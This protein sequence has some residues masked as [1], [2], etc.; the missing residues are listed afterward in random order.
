MDLLSL[1]EWHPPGEPPVPPGEPRPVHIAR[2]VAANRSRG[3]PQQGA[4]TKGG[5]RTPATDIYQE[6]VRA[7]G[8]QGLDRERT[9]VANQV[10][11]WYAWYVT[12]DRA[13]RLE[14]CPVEREFYAQCQRSLAP[15]PSSAL[16][17]LTVRPDSA[18]QPQTKLARLTRPRT[19]VG[20]VA[21]VRLAVTTMAPWR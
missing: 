10:R 12:H 6:V 4:T 15:S 2:T 21:R 16:R 9:A 1:I 7:L 14:A 18:S 20:C 17:V 3:R 5:S 11:R 19:G 8:G 13:L